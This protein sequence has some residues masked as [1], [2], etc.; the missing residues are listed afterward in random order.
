MSCMGFSCAA[1]LLQPGLGNSCSG[2]TEDTH[3]L[4]KTYS[5]GGYEGEIR[6]TSTGPYAL[7]TC[8]DEQKVKTRKDSKCKKIR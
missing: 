7:K 6:K 4:F 8:V 3:D 5:I 1:V 2:C